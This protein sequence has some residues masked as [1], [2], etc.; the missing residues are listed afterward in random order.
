MSFWIDALLVEAVSNDQRSKYIIIGSFS[1]S[2]K[3]III[4]WFFCEV[5][6]KLSF[7]IRFLC[8]YTK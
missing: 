8:S 2:T 3:L 6:A 1:Y 7:V 5:L 4:T